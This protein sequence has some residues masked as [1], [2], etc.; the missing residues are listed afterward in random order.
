MTVK[1]RKMLGQ[2]L[3]ESPEGVSIEGRCPKSGACAEGITLRVNAAQARQMGTRTLVCPGCGGKLVL[4]GIKTTAGVL[5]LGDRRMT[6]EEQ[7]AFVAGVQA[8]QA[9]AGRRRS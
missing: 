6:V 8:L 2:A 1:D 5:F 7:R 9:L 3:A 4:F